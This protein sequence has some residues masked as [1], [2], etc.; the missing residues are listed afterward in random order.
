MSTRADRIEATL[1]QSFAPTL[2]EVTDDSQ[3]HAGHAGA[4]P[5][6]QTHYAVLLVSPRFAGQSRVVRARAVHDSL[7]AEF[8]T[9]LHALALT[10][11]TP[12]EQAR[13]TTRM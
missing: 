1:H 4:A 13:A 9:G 10:L 11:R 3:R 7:A 6:G 5:G 12:E 2:L 8:G